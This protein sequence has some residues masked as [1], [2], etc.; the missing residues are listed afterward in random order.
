MNSHSLFISFHGIS[1]LLSKGYYK[2][3]EKLIDFIIE[4]AS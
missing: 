1:Q 4:A 2:D 3:N